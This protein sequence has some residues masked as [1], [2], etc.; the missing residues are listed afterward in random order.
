MKIVEL[1]KYLTI[2]LEGVIEKQE[3][4]NKLFNKIVQY[5]IARDKYFKYIIQDYGD[6]KTYLL[7]KFNKKITRYEDWKKLSEKDF[8]KVIAGAEYHIVYDILENAKYSEA[9]VM[10]TISTLMSINALKDKLRTLGEYKLTNEL[11]NDSEI[12]FNIWRH[13]TC[14]GSTYRTDKGNRNVKFFSDRTFRITC[15][16]RDYVYGKFLV[17][18]KYREIMYDLINKCQNN[19]PIPYTVRAILKSDVTENIW[20]IDF[21]VSLPFEYIIQFYQKVEINHE[22][23]TDKVTGHDI[24]IDRLNDVVINIKNLQIITHKTFWFEE[25]SRKNILKERVWNEIVKAIR[26]SIVWNLENN[27]CN[28]VF[29][30]YEFIG[31]WKLISTLRGKKLKS[32]EANWK[33]TTFRSSVIEKYAIELYKYNLP[34]PKVIDPSFTSKIAEEIHS[35]LGLDKH[36]ISAYLIACFGVIEKELQVH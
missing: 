17:H 12:E 11:P 28:H 9:V 34:L 3:H 26:E 10:E 22:I 30:D 13:I 14:I 16:Q 32:S 2:K 15:S 18:G 36:T 25:A 4:Q 23:D 24:N 6:L 33:I 20:K 29:E 31:D 27:S 7:K 21:H 1:P 35:F 5:N 8:V 19:N